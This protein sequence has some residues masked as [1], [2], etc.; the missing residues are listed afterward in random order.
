[1]DIA[2]KMDPDRLSDFVSGLWDAE[3]VPQLVEYIRIPNRSPMFDANWQQAGHMDRA[4]ALIAGWIALAVAALK[5]K[6]S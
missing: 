3:I 5:L 4:V 2:R 1:M 6:P